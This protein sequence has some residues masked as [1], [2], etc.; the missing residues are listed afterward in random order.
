MYPISPPP[1]K[2]KFI[3]EQ[4][5]FIVSFHTLQKDITWT[6]EIHWYIHVISTLLVVLIQFRWLHYGTNNSQQIAKTNISIYFRATQ[7]KHTKLLLIKFREQHKK[8]KCLSVDSSR[9]CSWMRC[10]CRCGDRIEQHCNWRLFR[11][12]DDGKWQARVQ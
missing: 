7:I 8:R 11:L 1:Q 10:C 12:L 3:A 5:G 9:Y 2:K 6:Y 4:R